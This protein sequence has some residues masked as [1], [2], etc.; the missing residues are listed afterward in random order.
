MSTLAAQYILIT[1]PSGRA[2]AT[3]VL[4]VA[5]ISKP[6]HSV[7]KNKW[8]DPKKIFPQRSLYQVS[9]ETIHFIFTRAVPRLCTHGV[10]YIKSLKKNWEK[11]T[12]SK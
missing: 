2:P 5:L 7:L 4:A 10:L 1:K 3:L 6:Q 11:L 8:P 9:L 12:R